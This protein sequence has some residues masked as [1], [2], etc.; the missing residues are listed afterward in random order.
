MPNPADLQIIIFMSQACPFCYKLKTKVLIDDRV[1][2][3]MGKYYGGKPLF[4]YKGTETYSE[5]KD[6]FDVVHLPC[7]IIMD[8]RR[9]EV[10]RTYF[11]EAQEMNEFLDLGE[12]HDY[13]Q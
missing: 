6:I 12:V 10:K 1:V 8:Q 5:A 11:L 2:R 4:L 3:S 13:S 7:I 9:N